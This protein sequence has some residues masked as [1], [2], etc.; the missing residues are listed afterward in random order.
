M[1]RALADTDH[2]RSRRCQ[3]HRAGTGNDEHGGEADQ[4]GDKFAA[5]EPPD[6]KGQ[7][8]Q[9]DYPWHKVGGD[10][11]DHPL[12]R[13]TAAL[14]LFHQFDDL[15]Q[16]GLFAHFGCLEFEQP[17]LVDRRADD[18]VAHRLRHGHTLAG[19][20]AL[21]DR[22]VTFDHH[23]IDRH[24]FAGADDDDVTLNHLGNRDVAFL[25]VAHDARSFGL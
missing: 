8:G 9:P 2:D 14:G 1:L 11:I 5:D 17:L 13:G 25:A 6:D 22:G 23:T 7:Q 3:P 20:H 12:N 18:G 19:D 15:G 24:L 10:L 4:G 21:V 16:G